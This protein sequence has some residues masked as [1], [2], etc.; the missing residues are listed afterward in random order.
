MIPLVS[1]TC[2]S[3]APETLPVIPPADMWMVSVSVVQRF[4]VLQQG[5]TLGGTD[6]PTGSDKNVASLA[7]IS[8]AL[9]IRLV[10]G[11][12]E[13]VLFH[14]ARNH[15]IPSNRFQQG[16]PTRLPPSLSPASVVVYYCSK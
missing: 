4:P 11:R 16:L 3:Q 5:C 8:L 14:S 2:F 6:H 1:T 10:F 7:R 9:E 13:N 12:G 15:T